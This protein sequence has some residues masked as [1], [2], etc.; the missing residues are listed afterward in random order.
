VR[1]DV[2]LFL[3]TAVV[4]PLLVTEFGDW[5]S[6]LAARLVR[7]AARHLGDPA[8]CERYQEEWIANL[9]EVPGKLARLAAAFGYL[10][11]LPRMRLSIRHRSGAPVTTWAGLTAATTRPVRELLRA[12]ALLGVDC[13]VPDLAIV[14]GRS[15]ADLLPVI[16]EACAIGVLAES[17]NGLAFRYPPISAALYDEIPAPVRTAWHRDAGRALAEAGR[18]ADRVTR[19]LLW[20]LGGSDGTAEPMDEW[21]LS[22]LAGPIGE[23]E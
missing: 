15:V 6:W 2:L 16:D 1:G 5:F 23:S 8:S 17:G 20:A 7:W 18:P 11:Y 19:Q 3:V 10:A 22:W 12:A 9:N 4:M 13:A 14:L 21:M